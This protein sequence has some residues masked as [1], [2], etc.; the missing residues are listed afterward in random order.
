MRRNPTYHAFHGSPRP[1]KAFGAPIF[2]SNGAMRGPGSYFATTRNATENFSAN[3]DKPGHVYEVEITLH[4]PLR[5]KPGRMPG[6]LGSYWEYWDED[7]GAWRDV[8]HEHEVMLDEH[9]VDNNDDGTRKTP[10][11]REKDRQAFLR[12]G[13]DGIVEEWS[14]VYVVFDPAASVRVVRHLEM[15]REK[16][17]TSEEA[18]AWR[19][20]Y[21]TWY[22]AKEKEKDERKLALYRARRVAEAEA[23][24]DAFAEECARVRMELRPRPEVTYWDDSGARVRNNPALPIAN[25]YGN[26]D[27]RSG[28]PAGYAHFPGKRL[29][30]TCKALGIDFAEAMDGFARSKQ[31]YKPTFDGVVVREEDAPRLREA[32]AQRDARRPTPAQRAAR[33]EAR[34]ERERRARADGFAYR[35]EQM[36]PGMPEADVDECAAHAT[37]PGSGRVG[38][39]GA[40]DEDEEGQDEQ[41]RRAVVAYARHRY[42]DYDARLAQGHDRGGARDD[43]RGDLSDVLRKWRET[44]R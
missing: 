28:V 40:F 38:R 2:G 22:E 8:P 31:G 42:T 44:P 9:Y 25:Q 35:I 29:S 1:I 39:V 4:R 17:L 43:I 37:E 34:R 10:A 12:A 24:E 41:V 15:H 33:N 27:V 36:F 13:Y 20:S 6:S 19:E 23:L 14:G 3:Y 11:Q 16:P 18:E 32:L 5:D 7:A 21:N 26:V 30:V